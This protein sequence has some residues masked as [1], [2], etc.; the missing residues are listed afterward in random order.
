[1]KFM[2]DIK[3]LSLLALTLLGVFMASLLFSSCDDEEGSAGETVLHSFG[4]SPLMRGGDL[5]FVGR[6]LDKVTSI[7]L[8]ENIEVTTFVTKSANLLVIEV[9]EPTVEGFVTLV[10]PQGN[11]VTKTRLGIAEPITIASISPGSVRPGEEITIEGTYLNLVTEV[12]FEDKKSVTEFVSQSASSLTVVV[13]ADAQTGIITLSDGQDTPNLIESETELTVITPNVTGFDP[14]ATIKAGDSLILEGTNLDLVKDITFQ[15]GTRLLDT[16]FSA[17]QT[18]TSIKV[19]VPANAADGAIIIRPASG[20]EIATPALT[21]VVPTITG[22]DNPGKNNGTIEITG[23]NLDLVSSVTFAD[24]EDGVNGVIQGGGT[25]TSITV[26]VPA[27]AV[28]GVISL[29]TNAGKSV[30]TATD[31]ELVVPVITNFTPASVNTAD[32]PTITITG[33]D[34]DIVTKIVFGGEGWEAEI[35]D[36]VSATDT[37]IEIPVTP[38]SLTGKITLVTTN[39][40]EVVSDDELTIVPDVPDVTGV[41]AAGVKPGEKITLTGTNMNVPATVYFPGSDGNDVVVTQFGAKSATTIEL[42]IPAKIVTG[43]SVR[44]KFV[45][46][47]NEISYSPKFFILKTLPE[48]VVEIYDEAPNTGIVGIGG[49]GGDITDLANTDEPRSGTTAIR[50]NYTG[51]WGGAAQF[52]TW[53]MDPISTAGATHFVFSIYSASPVVAGTEIQVNVKGASDNWVQIDVEQG[54]WIDVEIPLSSIGN[55]TALTEVAF[56]DRGWTGTVYIDY[57][58]L[59]N[60]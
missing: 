22:F 48:L 7:I 41:P 36:A 52:G 2:N 28:E 20:V 31:L 34:L 4:P 15:G 18:P 23:T 45:T 24:G 38:G 40:T 9:P 58:G 42:Y 49:W 19:K 8:P 59:I 29:N 57:I 21:M 25:A 3:K 16:V 32:S 26:Q 37:E 17:R 10:T 43:D 27:T 5:K 50:V 33:T 56:Q 53:G 35:G 14:G 1:M 60:K 39:G 54:N 11:I 6:N 12:I 44:V 30:A 47:R 51:G 46:D 55:P 13:P